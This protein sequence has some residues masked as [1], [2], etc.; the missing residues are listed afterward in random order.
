[1]VIRYTLNFTSYFFYSAGCCGCVGLPRAARARRCTPL[2]AA[3][4]CTTAHPG[5]G[6]SPGPWTCRWKNPSMSL[7]SRTRTS[8]HITSAKDAGSVHVPHPHGIPGQPS[9]AQPS[10]AQQ[11][12]AVRKTGGRRLLIHCEHWCLKSIYSF[13]IR[14]VWSVFS[15]RADRFLQAT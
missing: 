15:D 11:Q 7:H 5:A 3:H 14:S 12:V 9:S 8:H 4:H 13:R 1:M 10:P 6:H 2:H